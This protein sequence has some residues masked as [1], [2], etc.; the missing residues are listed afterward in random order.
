M[1]FQH[2][3][4]LGCGDPLLMDRGYP[5]RWLVALLNHRGIRFCMRVEK[6]GNSG[7]ASVRDFL[8]SG[9]QE[10]IVTLGAPDKADAADYECPRGALE[11]V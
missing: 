3:D 11:P 10:Q 1:L 9:L 8:R 4:L 5:C 6:E 7:F 2:L